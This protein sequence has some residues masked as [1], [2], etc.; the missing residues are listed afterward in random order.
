MSDRMMFWNTSS[1]PGP[2]SIMLGMPLMFS[3]ARWALSKA[4]GMLQL[5]TLQTSSDEQR[6]AAENSGSTVVQGAATRARS[7]NTKTPMSLCYL[8]AIHIYPA[9]LHHINRNSVLEMLVRTANTPEDTFSR[10]TRWEPSAAAHMTH[11]MRSLNASAAQYSCRYAQAAASGAAVDCK[12][13][14]HSRIKT[15][16]TQWF[17]LLAMQACQK[18][19]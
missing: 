2:I 12:L 10:P 17:Y 19:A 5:T 3:S 8:A 18:V 4:P 16:H 7:S 6:S 15:H 11:T 9:P 1:P 13:V 14:A